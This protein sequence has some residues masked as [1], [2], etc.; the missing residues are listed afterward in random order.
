MHLEA[1]HRSDPMLLRLPLDLADR[2]S[3]Q[4]GLVREARLSGKLIRKAAPASVVGVPVGGK[5][6]VGT[7]E[8]VSHTGSKYRSAKWRLCSVFGECLI[9]REE[10]C[11]GPRLS[12]GSCITLDKLFKPGAP[13]SHATSTFEV[14]NFAAKAPSPNR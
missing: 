10:S 3:S 12:L 14:L 11:L 1:S 6:H 5:A 7:L 4:N 8:T 2:L 9:P 13:E